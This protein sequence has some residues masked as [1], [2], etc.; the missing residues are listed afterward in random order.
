FVGFG[1]LALVKQ[2]IASLE[3]QGGIESAL[4]VDRGRRGESPGRFA[5]T[6]LGPFREA[7]PVARF[8]LQAGVVFQRRKNLFRLAI[9]AQLIEGGAVLERSMIGQWA[10]RKG[11]VKTLEK[12]G[13]LL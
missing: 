2:G 7:A 5:P 12:P 9:P 10:G 3:M 11:R 6:L 4:S 8:D 1:Q 13:C